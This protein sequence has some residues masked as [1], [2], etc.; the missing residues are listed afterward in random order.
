MT[1]RRFV[2]AL[3]KHAMTETG[4]RL[5]LVAGP[6]PHPA[7]GCSPAQ[8]R[9]FDLIAQGQPPLGG[10]GSIRTLMYRN[11]I[12]KNPYGA[13]YLV[14]PHARA[15]WNKWRSEQQRERG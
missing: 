12:T 3:N 1:R 11:L 9:D 7:A 13:G 5:K 15:W 10:Y 14:R 8:R 2:A 6:T 4:P